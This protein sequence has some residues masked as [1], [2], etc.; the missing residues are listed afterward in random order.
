MPD[1][2]LKQLDEVAAAEHRSRSEV[3]CEALRWYFAKYM[4][5]TLPALPSKP[6]HPKAKR[7]RRGGKHG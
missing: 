6:R 4:G 2:L 5:I 1:E 3:I 7:V